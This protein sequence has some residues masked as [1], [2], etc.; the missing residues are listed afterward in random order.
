V[1][2]HPDQNALPM[3]G[4]SNELVQRF[5]KTA[6]DPQKP[7]RTDTIL[8]IGQETTGF[9]FKPVMIHRVNLTVR[10]SGVQ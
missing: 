2:Q 9:D 6:S 8:K 7:C 10:R 5:F 1:V 4:L 3:M